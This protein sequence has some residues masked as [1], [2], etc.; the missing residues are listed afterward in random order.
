[1]SY[2]IITDTC[3]DYPADMYQELDLIQTPLSVT[4]RGQ[5]IKEYP[6]SFL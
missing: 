6:E 1:M 4:Y 3:C 5:T 2:R